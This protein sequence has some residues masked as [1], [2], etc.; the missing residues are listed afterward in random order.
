MRGGTPGR[1]V[2]AALLVTLA[3][4]CLGCATEIHLQ[5]S[6]VAARAEGN[7]RLQVR[8]F[9]D[10]SERRHELS[11]RLRVVS[12]LYRVEGAAKK[13]VREETE[14]RWTASD[15]PPGEYE[16]QVNRW[17]DDQGTAQ[18]F[19]FKYK[20]KFAI[21]ANETAMADV[22][23]ADAYNGWVKVVIGAAVVVGMAYFVGHEAM[24]AWR[25]LAGGR[26][27]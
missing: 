24:E 21:R 22:V 10:R 6:A 7:G 13:L 17:I 25:P 12:E 9:E 11:S 5:R 23:L 2:S 1:L 16:L 27:H 15:L 14:S 26:V 18:V 8:V 4:W 3:P 20:G 19:P